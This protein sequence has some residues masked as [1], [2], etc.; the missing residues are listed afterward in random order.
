VRSPRIGR[1]GQVFQDRNAPLAAASF[2]R[3]FSIYAK[4]SEML[5]RWVGLEEEARRIKPSTRR[6]GQRAEDDGSSESPDAEPP[7]DADASSGE[8]TSGS[9]PAAPAP[10]DP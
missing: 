5:Y 4:S 1:G 6:S 2:Q 10:A 9:A 3:K 7:S 8:A